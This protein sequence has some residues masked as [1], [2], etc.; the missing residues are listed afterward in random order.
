MGGFF[1]GR[2]QQAALHRNPLRCKAELGLELRKIQ[3]KFFDAGDGY[4]ESCQQCHTNANHLLMFIVP[5]APSLGPDTVPVPGHVL[6]MGAGAVGCY[7]GGCL[8]AVGVNV[9]FVGRPRVLDSLSQHGLCLSDL[10]GGHRTLAGL[11]LRLASEIPIDAAPALVLLTVKSAATAR[12]ASQLQS[13][14]PA[15]TLVVSLQNG[16]SN[17]DVARTAAPALHVVPGMVPYNIAEISPGHFHRG[18]TGSLAAQAHPA[19][20]TWL[21]WFKRALNPLT[22]HADLVP[23]QWGKLLLNLNNPVNALSGQPLRAQLLERGYRRILAALMDEALDT[24]RCANIAPAKIT[25]IAPRWL[26]TL[27]RLPTPLF[28]VLA[29]RM[30]RMD[31]KA[32]SSMADDLTLNRLTE[33]DAMCGEIVRLA[34]AQG[35][36]APL[37]NKMTALIQHWPIRREAMSA[38]ALLVAMNLNK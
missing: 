19:L 15:G 36:S 5:K 29:A 11:S 38:Q 4:L 32:R 23:V 22:L 21:P 37:N 3:K 9:T 33:V 16:I 1:Y 26:P 27:L 12:A 10:D 30:L 25:P 31:D 7:V 35:R 13:C 34:T 28:R 6:V 24:L 2:S 8:Q 18:T 14:L 20:S 17:A